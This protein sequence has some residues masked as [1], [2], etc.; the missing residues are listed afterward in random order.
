[1]RDL[2]EEIIYPNTISTIHPRNKEEFKF[3]YTL[4]L[5][6]FIHHKT[7][8]FLNASFKSEHDWIY[9]PYGHHDLLIYINK[10]LCKMNCEIGQVMGQKCVII[11][12]KNLSVYSS[13]KNSFDGYDNDIYMHKQ[14]NRLN[15]KDQYDLKTEISF[16]SGLV[17]VLGF[18][19]DT[20][21]FEFNHSNSV[22]SDVLEYKGLYVMDPSY[23]LDFMSITCDQ[24]VPVKM[25]FEFKE[26]LLLCPIE[27]STDKKQNILIS[28]VPKNCV[29]SLRPGIIRS[30]HFVVEDLNGEKIY[31]NS[32]K[33][34][35]ICSI[36]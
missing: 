13:A 6:R 2:E 8:G 32:R 28:F 5:K 36:I 20:V 18:T 35:L 14:S 12:N 31:F 11:C 4:S 9:I 26:R 33:I 10:Y 27:L 25:G 29:R 23:G 30:M 19:D 24:I 3:K 21:T 34:I 16:S 1:M 22:S 17:H 7:T 15:D